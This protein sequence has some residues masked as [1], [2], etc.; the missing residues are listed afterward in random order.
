MYVRTGIKYV[1]I[2]TYVDLVVLEHPTPNTQ[3][4]MR[5]MLLRIGEQGA[6]DREWQ[7]A[8]L[9]FLSAHHTLKCALLYE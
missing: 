5:R 4:R 8:A 6:H 7:L 2:R 1:L 3:Q 9:I